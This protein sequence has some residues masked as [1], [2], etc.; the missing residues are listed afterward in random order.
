MLHRR[1]MRQGVEE[2]DT[3]DTGRANNVYNAKKVNCPH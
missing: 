2:T 1:N 3:E